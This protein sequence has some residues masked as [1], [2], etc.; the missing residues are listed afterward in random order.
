M[1][2]FLTNQTIERVCI[3]PVKALFCFSVPHFKTESRLL[4]LFK[5]DDD[6]KLEVTSAAIFFFF[7]FLFSSFLVQE[8]EYWILDSGFHAMDSGCKILDWTRDSNR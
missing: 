5:G 8:T 6:L 3:Q 7:S 4:L 2:H 1:K